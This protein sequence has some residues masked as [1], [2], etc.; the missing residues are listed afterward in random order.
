MS[1]ATT[2]ELHAADVTG[3]A[4]LKL[5][6]AAVFAKTVFLALLCLI[7]LT[8]IPYGTSQPWWIAAFVSIIFTLAILWLVEGSMG[9]SWFADSW[10]VAAP[11]V[12]LA[13][14][15]L[16]QTIS[17]RNGIGNPGEIAFA[18]W[19]TISAD[20]YQTR[21][22]AAQVLALVITGILLSRYAVTERRMRVTIN[23]VLCVAVASAVFGILRQTTQRTPGF[24]LPLL[25]PS[26]GYGQ[27]INK[28]HFAFLIEMSLGLI[29]G[30]LLGGG[31]KREQALIYFAA[32]LPL[33]MGLV[34]SGSRGGLIA[35]LAQLIVAALLMSRVARKGIRD[36]HQ[37]RLVKTADSPAV[38]ITLVVVLIAGVVFGTIWL[39]GDRLASSIEE[40]R[41]ELSADTS[42]L[43]QGA[44]RN[45]IWRAS[46]RMFLAH[47]I[48]GL[49]LGGYW[50][51]IPAFHDASGTITPQEAHNDYLEL[52]ASGGVVGLALGVWFAFVVF[53]RTRENLRS[54]NRFRRA[55]CYGAAIGIAGV[56][57]HSLVD[58]GLHTIT[59][60][61]VFTTLI[62][63]ATS[64]PPWGSERTR[65]YE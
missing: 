17:L 5:R 41:Q 53:R 7:V 8:A 52:L 54:P 59:N 19:N 55:A 50:A 63:I 30:L 27:F 35:M 58:F 20:P 36:G 60:A 12:A 42:G 13:F 64:K 47:P 38:R 34:L 61:L 4:A 2:A 25:L 44:S 56:A 48:L 39:G 37:S 29:L 21:F 28:N 33:W 23:V 1:Q 6:V 62:V 10:P 57:V 9:H 22:V 3:R 45:E 51:A 40:S 18:P 65:L 31:I 49:G 16:L 46:W 24:G 26:L 32:M 15:S 43:R 14:F 11:L